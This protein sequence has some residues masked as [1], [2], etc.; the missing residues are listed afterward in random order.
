M[1]KNTELQIVQLARLKEALISQGVEAGSR[2]KAVSDVTGYS[3][4]TVGNL[5]SGSVS[6][7]VKFIRAVCSAFDIRMEW[8]LDGIEPKLEPEKRYPIKFSEIDKE[9][10]KK[11]A[12]LISGE[13][14]VSKDDEQID[15]LI[16]KR[17]GGVKAQ[18]WEI[19][20][21]IY[22]DEAMEL[23]KYLRSQKYRSGAENLGWSGDAEC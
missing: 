10:F 4:H 22:E 13:S 9:N 8:V 6:L 3:L 18:L 15:F 7:S 1:K 12:A 21:A 17:H 16:Y 23:L 19:I 11:V 20:E 5:L 14:Q 2:N